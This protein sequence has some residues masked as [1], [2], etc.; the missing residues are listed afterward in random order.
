MQHIQNQYGLAPLPEI[1]LVVQKEQ[2]EDD[3]AE[4]YTYESFRQFP[5][6]HGWYYKHEDF[7]LHELKDY[8]G[9]RLKKKSLFQAWLFFR[10]IYTVIKQGEDRLLNFDQLLAEN[11]KFFIGTQNLPDALKKWHHAEKADRR[12][13]KSRLIRA[14]L[15]LELA[16]QV[17]QANL[18]PPADEAASIPKLDKSNEINGVSNE[19]ALSLMVIGET[20]SS[21]KSRIIDDLDV[22][23]K[24]WHVDDEIGWGPPKYVLEQMKARH[25]CRRSVHVLKGQLGSNA[26][27]LLVALNSEFTDFGNKHENCDIQKCTVVASSAPGGD[28]SHQHV[29][30][31]SDQDCEMI[32]PSGG[33]VYNI[34]RKANDEDEHE[35]FPI[36]SITKSKDGKPE[37]T[38]IVA[39]SWHKDKPLFATISHVWSDGMGNKTCNAVYTCQAEFIGRLLKKASQKTQNVTGNGDIEWFW[40]DT[41]GIPVRPNH[42]L[43]MNDSNSSLVEEGQ[44]YSVQNLLEPVPQDFDR[45][46]KKAIRQI[47]SVFSEARHAIII[48]RGLYNSTESGPPSA[49]IMKIFVSGWMQRLWTLQEAYL[50]KRLWVTFRHSDIPDTEAGIRDFDELLH[51]IDR[52]DVITAATQTI[53]Q[54]KII[55]NIMGAERA[56]RRHGADP[57]DSSGSLLVANAWR[58]VRWRVSIQ[59]DEVVFHITY[60]KI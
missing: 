43:Q 40:L 28:Y 6:R 3:S 37:K 8:S 42:A 51:D 56:S 9:H 4:K 7:T 60:L 30:G 12:S 20:L 57:W 15:T 32:G 11:N 49:V 50:S 13:A 31:C 44:R 17:I 58:A 41:L 23:V 52:N 5:K 53:T 25:W 29:P 38:K 39:S 34:L 35:R 27:L 54:Q 16:R 1:T 46:K 14:D 26:S 10:L 2:C 55:H 48:D 59:P 22:R 36:F 24:G 33:D 47:R 45:L 18:V 19:L 21:A